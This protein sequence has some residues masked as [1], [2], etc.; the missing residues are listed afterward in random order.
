MLAKHTNEATIQFRKHYLVKIRIKAQKSQF[1]QMLH[2]GNIL[3]L[4][5]IPYTIVKTMRKALIQK[6][7]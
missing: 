6:I 4:S 2:H 3:Y 1:G 7:N 5:E